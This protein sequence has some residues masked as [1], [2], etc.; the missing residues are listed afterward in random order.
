MCGFCY[1]FGLPD[2][3]RQGDSIYLSPNNNYVAT[4]DSFGRVILVDVER[5][6]AVRMWK[7]GRVVNSILGLHI[8]CTLI[9]IQCTSLYAFNKKKR[10]TTTCIV[11]N[12]GNIMYQV[13]FMLITYNMVYTTQLLI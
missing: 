2:K 9:I 1:R 10:S 8:H 3:R 5:G 11:L 4:T 13:Y 6:T 12:T 7:G